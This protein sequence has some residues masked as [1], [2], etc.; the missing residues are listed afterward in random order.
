[1]EYAETPEA[2]ADRYR[3]EA[4]HLRALAVTFDGPRER[5]ELLVIADSYDRLADHLTVSDAREPN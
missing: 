3:R 2:R 1:M 5:A 4:A